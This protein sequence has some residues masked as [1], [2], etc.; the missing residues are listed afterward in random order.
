MK[1]RFLPV[2][3]FLLMLMLPGWVAA[4]FD[5]LY[6][7]SRKDVLPAFAQSAT[8]VNQ[9]AVYATSY[10][11]EYEDTAY[12]EEVYDDYDYSYSNRIR[13]FHSP[14]RVINNYSF[15][16]WYD[17]FYY[18]PFFP[19]YSVNVFVG[20]P[21]VRPW[22]W[23]SWNTGWGWNSWNVGWNSW[24]RP[25]GWNAWNTGWGWNSCPSFWTVNNNHFYGD[26]WNSW[27]NNSN[28]AIYSS[29]RAGSVSSSTRGID[30]S[31]RR[32]ISGGGI[33]DPSGRTPDAGI[34]SASG[35]TPSNRGGADR[36]RVYRGDISAPGNE[37]NR[38]NSNVSGSTRS[39]IHR[40]AETPRSNSGRSDVNSGSNRSNTPAAKPDN[41]A[42][43]SNDS[44]I[45]SSRGSNNQ[46]NTIQRPA[47]DQ[48]RNN[49]MNQGSSRS[50]DNFNN[51]SGRSSSG[52]GSFNSGSS[53]SSSGGSMNSGGG[54]SRSS[55]GGGGSRRGGG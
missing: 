26:G 19:E 24:N 33:S 21:F 3:S 34:N 27:N 11:D 53:R 49:N 23:N 43:P 2:L 44:S 22:G 28:N 9:N 1:T 30:A 32:E 20:S 50:N 17:D 10:Y 29:R 36:S 37:V 18:D 47:P 7:D 41:S 35:V 45:R 4:Q 48:S 13:R 12:R 39:S 42:R 31:P 55:S 5:D 40:R 16:S 46:N 6:F 38:D 54:S 51:S 14:A 52:S 8:A 25:W 15:N